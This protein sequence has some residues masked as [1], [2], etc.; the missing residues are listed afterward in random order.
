M[1]CLQGFLHHLPFS[2]VLLLIRIVCVCVCV[3][4]RASVRLCVCV[5]LYL[6]VCVPK[7]LLPKG[8]GWDVVPTGKGRQMGR[9]P[10]PEP[11]TP[12]QGLVAVWGCPCADLLAEPSHVRFWQK[13]V[14]QGQPCPPPPPSKRLSKRNRE[15]LLRSEFTYYT[16]VKAIKCVDAGLDPEGYTKV[17]RFLSTHGTRHQVK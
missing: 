17:V 12:L 13:E 14:T 6:C 2:V 15:Q 7:V 11:Q 3:C 9:G 1:Q 8:N 10:D 4:A 5:F 16:T